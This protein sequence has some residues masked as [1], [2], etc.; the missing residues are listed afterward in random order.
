[1]CSLPLKAIFF[2]FILCLRV[3]PFVLLQML[4]HG[5]TLSRANN[6]LTLP[7]TPGRSVVIYIINSAGQRMDP[8]VIPDSTSVHFIA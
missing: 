1:M 5:I 2:T 6:L 3:T 4:Y 7:T 8:C